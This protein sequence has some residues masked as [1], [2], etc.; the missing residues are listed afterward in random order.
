ML[1]VRGEGNAVAT[2]VT[3]IWEGRSGV[4]EVDRGRSRTGDGPPNEAASDAA[5]AERANTEPA[6]FGIL[7]DRY[8][9]PIY[10]YCYARLGTKETAEDA[11]SQVF[12]A[13]LVALPRYRDRGGGSF[14]S[15]LFTIAHNAITDH[16][17][18]QGWFST[19]D[20]PDRP[21]QAEGPE[22]AALAAEQRQTMRD[23]LAALPPDQRRVVELRLAGLSGPEIARTLGRS[24]GSVKML[25]LRAME[26]LRHRLGA[27]STSKET[28][29]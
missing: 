17:R 7:Y 23:L 8:A 3:T 21:D 9:A 28:V 29:R 27:D 12:A 19:D 1:T 25:Q 15:W 26:G 18:R 6:V 20:P 22:A 14:R 16:H 10:R 13:A 5:L 11:T 4:R 24:H 2:T